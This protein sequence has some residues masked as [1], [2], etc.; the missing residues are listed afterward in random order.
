MRTGP[1]ILIP[2]LIIGLTVALGLGAC[3]RGGGEDRARPDDESETP[4]GGGLGLEVDSEPDPPRSGQ[5]V[6]W[7]ITVRNDGAEAVTL[8]FSSGRPGDVVLTRDG[9]EVYR[10]SA[11]RF[12][13]E[14]VRHERLKP[15]EEK[16][17]RLDEKALDVPPGE[18]EL[19]AT[20]ASEPAPDARRRTVT[21]DGPP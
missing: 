19:T 14:A 21:I 8:T 12:F 16:V 13:T 11:D 5:A 18:Y 9:A 10:W 1:V 3:G 4:V 6:D 2:A 7:L 17:Y 15:N 20:L